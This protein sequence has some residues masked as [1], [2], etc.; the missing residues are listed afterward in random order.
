MLV[1]GGGEA[2]GPASERVIYKKI[3]FLHFKTVFYMLGF[4]GAPG[5]QGPWQQQ[6][7]GGVRS[8]REGKPLGY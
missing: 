8:G 6:E 5:W 7:G 2:Q 1:M 4:P 3:F